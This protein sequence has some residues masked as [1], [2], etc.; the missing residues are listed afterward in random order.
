M[1]P[2]MPELQRVIVSVPTK[3]RAN[4]LSPL[5]TLRHKQRSGRP[6]R[7]SEKFKALGGGVAAD[8]TEH[9]SGLEARSRTRIVLGILRWH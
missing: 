2:V 5:P 1:L 7:V 3:T 4:E 8:K 9:V 6:N